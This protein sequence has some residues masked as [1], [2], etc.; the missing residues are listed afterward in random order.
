MLYRDVLAEGLENVAADHE[1]VGELAL[2]RETRRRNKS[3]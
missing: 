2:D 3:G 1:L